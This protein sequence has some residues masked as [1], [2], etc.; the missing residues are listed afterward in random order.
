MLLEWNEVDTL[1]AGLGH[2]DDRFALLYGPPGTGKTTAARRAGS[3]ASVFSV[4]LTDETPAAEL[5][6]H[7]VPKGGEYVWMDGP[8]SRWARQGGRLVL[9]EINHASG[10]ALDFLQGALNDR[11]AA[12]IN[13]PTGET[14]LV[15][16][17]CTAIATM[18]GV[19]D[20][21]PEAVADRFAIRILVDVPHPAAMA[22]FS[23]AVQD[24]IRGTIGAGPGRQTS[25]RAWKSFTALADRL[26]EETAARAVFEDRH[27]EVMNALRLAGER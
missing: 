26:D 18:N 19:P 7:F 27:A 8:I 1:L 9:D 17:T 22:G 2:A 25:L 10:D 5:R 16:P 15:D 20:D 4:T 13:L 6:G 11:D 21:L 24:A 14:I 23:D 12:E 3:P